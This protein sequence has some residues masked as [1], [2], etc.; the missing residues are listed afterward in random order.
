MSFKVQNLKGIDSTHFLREVRTQVNNAEITTR[1][2]FLGEQYSLK[3]E[4]KDGDGVQT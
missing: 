2:F 1:W 4:Q 3:T